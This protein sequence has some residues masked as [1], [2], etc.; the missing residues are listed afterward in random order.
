VNDVI[1]VNAKSVYIAMFDE[2]DEGTAMFKLAENDDMIP[3]EGY[4]LPLD[5]DGYDLPSDWYLRTASLATQVVRG[6]E[7]L[8]ASLGTPPEGIMTI[9]IT[10]EANDDNQG[11]LEFIF[12]DFPVESTIEISIDGGITFPYSTPDDAGTYTISGL[13]EGTYLV[14]A[15]HGSASPA[16][17]MGDVTIGNVYEGLPD[18]A[19][20]PF[21]ADNE[22]GVKVNTILGW[23]AGAHSVSHHVY[24][25]TTQT[26]DSM[27]YQS[28]TAFNPGELES[29]TTYYWRIDEE[30]GSGKTEG[31]LWNFT[32][33]AAG[34]PSDIVVLDYCDEVTGWKSPNGLMLDSEDKMEG[35]ASL[36]CE[37]TSANKFN[38]KFDNP[39]NTLCDASSYLNL[40]LYVSDVSKFNGGGQIELSSAGKNDIDELNWSV[41]GL[42]L[43]NGWNEL[44]LQIKDAS[45]M[46]NPDLS[47]INFFRFYQHVS[48]EIV[49]KID[50]IYFS[51]LA[52][53]P[54]TSVDHIE[55]LQ[56]FKL[57]PN[58]AS[59]VCSIQ[60]SMKE[61]ADVSVCI[62]DVSGRELHHFIENEH[63]MSGDYTLRLPLNGFR[64]GAYILRVKVD[65]TMITDL[66]VI[67]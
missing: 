47:A 18:Q 45:T 13:S 53:I 16:V 27:T 59:S 28:T 66:L 24:F 4:W 39:V 6:H 3:R 48:S 41:P 2:I 33:G 38:K 9:R 49:T 7:D 22:T 14:F 51:E 10:D 17:D 46:G 64:K 12:P 32:T 58:P 29:N 5:E 25:G 42:N 34:G 52:G 30:N 40:W 57:Y 15:R 20:N 43:S 63:W 36:S 55:P 61:S 26:P 1:P 19:S 8:D 60:F 35:F 23:R 50:Y 11:A 54:G 62:F 44:H 21:P 31:K 56:E 67:D 37:G 65:D